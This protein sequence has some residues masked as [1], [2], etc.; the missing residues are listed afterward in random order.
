MQQLTLPY[1]TVTGL[2]LS[3]IQKIRSAVRQHFGFG[4]AFL[5]RPVW[6]DARDDLESQMI[7]ITSGID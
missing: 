3:L 7:R 1:L 4:P 2:M 6:V 5:N